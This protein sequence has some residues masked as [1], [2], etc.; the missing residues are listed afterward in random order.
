MCIDW[1]V[2]YFSQFYWFS[3][4]NKAHICICILDSGKLP[5]QSLVCGQANS[6]IGAYVSQTTKQNGVRATT[7]AV[8]I[9]LE[10]GRIST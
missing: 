5:V 3:W 4:K 10:V 1:E 6:Q 7:V 8:E 2:G 9:G